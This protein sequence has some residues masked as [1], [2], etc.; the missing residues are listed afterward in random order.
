MTALVVKVISM[1]A[2]RQQMVM[3]QPRRIAR[4]VPLSQIQHSVGYLL[5]VQQGDGSFGDPH[6]VLHR[7]LMVFQ[8][9]YMYK[10]IQ[11]TQ[12]SDMC[13]HSNLTVFVRFVYRLKAT[14][15]LP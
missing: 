1:I 5:S 7:G 11:A 2:E 12:T 4:V 10:Y 6:P 8:T 15:K 14:A 9:I 3:G 13:S